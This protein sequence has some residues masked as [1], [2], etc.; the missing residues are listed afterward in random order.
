MTRRSSAV[1][2]PP[3]QV[4]VSK[5]RKNKA[6]FSSESK[7]SSSHE[8][9]QATLGTTLFSLQSE[10]M[11]QGYRVLK[12]RPQT[13]AHSLPSGCPHMDWRC[14]DPSV[15]EVMEALMCMTWGK[16]KGYDGPEGSCWGGKICDSL[17]HENRPVLVCYVCLEHTASTGTSLDTAGLLT[18]LW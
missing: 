15:K 18:Q 6:S 14:W 3:A 13:E 10:G 16:K 8:P 7:K 1:T 2:T 17:H 11:C 12:D 5:W 9:G 4:T